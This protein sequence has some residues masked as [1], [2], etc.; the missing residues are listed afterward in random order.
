[1][2]RRAFIVGTTAAALLP[3]LAHS[4]PPARRV[5]V[6]VLYDAS[7][8]PN[9]EGIAD[10]DAALNERLAA[11]GYSAESNLEWNQFYVRI[12]AGEASDA[13][14][15]A[16][17]WKPDVILTEAT[18][19]TL[20]V[21]KATSTIPVVFMN[22]ADPLGSGVVTSLARPG[23]N[24]T[25]ASQFYARLAFKRLELTREILPEARSVAVAWD[26]TFTYWA[27]FHE[28]FIEAA[29]RLGLRVIEG[30][31]AR[32]PGGWPELLRNVQSARPD[33]LLVL[34]PWPSQRDRAPSN[35]AEFQER[36]RIPVI[37][38]IINP[39]RTELLVMLGA[40]NMDHVRR[41]AD[42][43]ARVMS[44]ERP[45]DISVDQATR[46]LLQVNLRTAR[47]LGIKVPKSVLLRADRIIE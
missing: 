12:G 42:I 4:Q 14:G 31:M 41:S 33:A 21:K 8:H 35:F 1:M 47:R 34:G 46:I 25:G 6:A 3:L 18:P 7:A 13:I 38:G 5:R 43:L 11:L 44:G 27:G 45:G 9:K 17:E 29:R 37:F 40:D 20:A 23:A 16:I 28:E 30:D 24:I 26:R 19:L 15:R 22:V 2:K 10:T 36:T 32:S 39:M